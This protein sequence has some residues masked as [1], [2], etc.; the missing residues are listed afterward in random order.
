MSTQSLSKDHL[1]VI[2]H[3][4]ASTG[5]ANG[6][7]VQPPVRQNKAAEEELLQQQPISQLKSMEEE[8]LPAQGKFVLQQA[9]LP[10]EEKLMQ[11]KFVTQF[12]PNSTGMPDQVKSGVEHLSGMD[13]SDVKVHYNSEKPSQLNAYAYAQGND[14]HLGSG[15]EKHLPH[16]AWH[17][18]QQR[19]G[20]V[21]ATTQLKQ[22]VPVNDDPGLENE[23]DVMGAK[24]LQTA[25][26][27]HVNNPEK[28]A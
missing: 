27:G 13:L 26:M 24:A 11:G 25:A 20:R 8:E 14:I 12:K 15:Q 22:G 7:S 21:Q 28:E 9:A 16:E 6:I 4:A 17:V 19:Q 10:E 3:A 23:A 2:Q 5:T 1:P 18:V